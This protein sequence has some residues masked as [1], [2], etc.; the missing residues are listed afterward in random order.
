MFQLVLI[1]LF[2]LFLTAC[3]SNPPAPVV[4]RLP[5]SSKPATVTKGGAKPNQVSN[6]TTRN[7]GRPNSHTVKKGD[8]LFSIGLEYGLE[9][10]EIAAANN[11]TPPY[12]IEIG[13]K[14]N[15]PIVEAKSDAANSNASAQ[16]TTEDGVVITPIKTDS[17][18]IETTV[19]ETK[20]SPTTETKPAQSAASGLL[21]E[22]KAM[23]EPYS[24][25]AFNRTTPVKTT[26]TKVAVGKTVGTTVETKVNDVK[27]GEIKPAENKTADPKSSQT[28][29][30]D[31]EAIKWSWPTQGKV[32][33]SFNEATNKGIDIAGSTGQAINAA[34]S[35]KVIY[36]GSDLRG[37]GKLVIIKHNKTYLSV[38]AHNSKI[39]VKEGQVVGVGQK[40]AEMGNTDS[41]SV[42]LHFEIRRLGKSVD[43]AKY[44]NQN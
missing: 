34:S 13:Q 16:V 27:A 26:E 44:L 19:S 39:I 14:L 12:T 29:P 15:L 33:A 25:E 28:Q 3:E 40:I 37:Y 11:I 30:P 7:D 36:S 41:N 22:P 43:P 18:A 8:T 42:K 23:R 35:G 6:S 38:Y 2:A 17:T 24:L 1:T 32:V 20:A 4:D 5:Q 31:D 9:Y 21:N 10:K